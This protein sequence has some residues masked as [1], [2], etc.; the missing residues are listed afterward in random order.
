MED[1]NDH[2]K[3]VPLP[4]QRQAAKQFKG[5][6]IDSAESGVIE[7]ETDS[8]D[9]VPDAPARPTGFKVPPP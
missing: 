9:E 7:L 4:F 6:D 5:Q 2:D 8:K 1:L 3:W